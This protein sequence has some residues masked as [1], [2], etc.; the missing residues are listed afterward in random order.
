MSSITHTSRPGV[1]A[2]CKASSHLPLQVRADV[3]RLQVRH[4]GSAQRQICR[5]RQRPCARQASARPEARRPVV[6]TRGTRA[7]ALDGAAHPLCPAATGAQTGLT[8]VA[9]SGMDARLRSLCSRA[10]SCK[11]L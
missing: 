9:P 2:A 8:V 5:H 10:S 4:P 1:R 11:L 7:R 3:H 6:E